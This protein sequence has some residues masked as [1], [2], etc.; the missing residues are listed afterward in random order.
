M[1]LNEIFCEW[2]VAV[3]ASFAVWRAL[4]LVKLSTWNANPEISPVIMCTSRP[5]GW[6]KMEIPQNSWRFGV[7]H[8]SG[9][10]MFHRYRETG[11][12]T[13]RARQ[14]RHHATTRTQTVF[15]ALRQRFLTNM[16]QSQLENVEVVRISIETN[17]Q[18]LS[19][20]T[21]LQPDIPA[22]GID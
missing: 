22:R 18:R 3:W 1:L 4:N 10:R 5:V 15:S 19:T 13:R 17:R 6:K 9:S 7:S 2:E 12:H 8:T 11:D 14:G 20:E 21:N 16:L